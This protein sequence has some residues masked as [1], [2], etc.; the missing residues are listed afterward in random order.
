MGLQGKIEAIIYAAEEPVTLDQL[1]ILL[2][3]DVFAELE[4]QAASQSAA[5]AFT[6]ESSASGSE[7]GMAGDLTEAP[8]ETSTGSEE[9]SE[10]RQHPERAPDSQEPL[11]VPESLASSG[12]ESATTTESASETV[13]ASASVSTGSGAAAR[14]KKAADP[15]LSKVKLHLRGV[16]ARV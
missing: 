4:A 3:R 5:L 10:A 12:S 1:A 2:K 16:M 9:P 7:F 15:E 6:D 14:K 8:T 11:S 13:N